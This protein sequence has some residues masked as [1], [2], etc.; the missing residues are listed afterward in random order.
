M[1]TRSERV[2]R[3]ANLPG[4]MSGMAVPAYLTPTRKLS[5]E[6]RQALTDPLPAALTRQEAV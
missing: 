2:V 4:P 3:G 5:W 1:F 6:T